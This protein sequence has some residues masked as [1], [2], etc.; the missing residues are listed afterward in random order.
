MCLVDFGVSFRLGEQVSTESYEGTTAYSAP[1][2]LSS[3]NK[4]QE[5]SE[6]SDLFALGVVMFIL[7]CGVHPFDK[8]NSLSD[9]EVS[10]MGK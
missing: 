1:E 9:D 8:Y 10:T 3:V 4:A 7:L 6:A 5:V 2:I